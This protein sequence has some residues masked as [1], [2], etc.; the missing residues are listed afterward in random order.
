[1]ARRTREGAARLMR[2]TNGPTVQCGACG[3]RFWTYDEKTQHQ[4]RTASGLVVCRYS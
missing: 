2:L 1:M 4:G 3:R